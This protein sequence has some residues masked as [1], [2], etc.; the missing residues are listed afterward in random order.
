MLWRAAA[1]FQVSRLRISRVWITTASHPQRIIY[2]SQRSSL[3]SRRSD[4]FVRSQLEAR[5]LLSLLAWL[6]AKAVSSGPRGKKLYARPRGTPLAVP[7]AWPFPSSHLNTWSLD[8][9]SWPLVCPLTIWLP[10]GPPFAVVR[11]MDCYCPPSIAL[12][13]ACFLLTSRICALKPSKPRGFLGPQH[14]SM[15]LI[16]SLMTIIAHTIGEKKRKERS[17]CARS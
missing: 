9:E 5:S 10:I 12:D 7:Q 13:H 1:F 2:L 14:S 11:N 16:V 6:L 4:D 17:R 15:S 8:W 3:T